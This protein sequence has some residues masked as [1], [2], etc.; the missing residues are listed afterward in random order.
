MR[1]DCDPLGQKL[2]RRRLLALLGGSLIASGSAGSGL[3]GAGGASSRMAVLDWA[4]AAT[5]LA[6]GGNVIGVPAIDYYSRSV[7]EPP[8]PDDV[9]DV[10]LLFTPNF[11][12][13][14]QL[15]PDLIVIPPALRIGEPFLQ[16]IAATRVVDL[17]RDGDA[18]IAAAIEGTG[19]LAE[20]I[21]RQ[22]AWVKLRSDMERQ[23][24]DAAAQLAR[25]RDRPLWIA[26]SAD[27][28]HLTVFGPGSLF[29]DIL[30]RLGLVNAQKESGFWRGQATV[31]LERIAAVPEAAL[32]LIDAD[33]S[34]SVSLPGSD[35]V[36]WQA[37]PVVRE[38]RVFRLPPVMENGGVPAVMRFSRLLAAG[39]NGGGG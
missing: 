32:V 27:D 8:M 7:V 20:V 16:R 11:E 38:G 15:S 1:A 23:L 12:L 26:T 33:G 36:F 18:T 10:G 14:D 3:A 13:L 37:L 28:R 17:A 2:T 30:N 29:A 34:N 5:A 35:S 25:W 24:Q 39:L 31:G 19:H 22:S 9:V 6:L 4:L 21:D